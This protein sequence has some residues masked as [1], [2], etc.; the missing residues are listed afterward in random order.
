MGS[1]LNLKHFNRNELV[2]MLRN[3]EENV[4]VLINSY[5]QEIYGFI[6]RLRE[7]AKTE[8]RETFL[9][10]SRKIAVASKSVCFELMHIMAIE[11]EECDFE[12]KNKILD[13]VDE[14]ENELEIVKDILGR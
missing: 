13:C 12:S 4:D 11:L 1:K 6:K 9:K 7:S 5:F 10:Y 14:M 2:D 8:D 3:K